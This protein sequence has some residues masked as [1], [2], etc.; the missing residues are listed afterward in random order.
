MPNILWIVL[1][2]VII[3]ALVGGLG[4]GFHGNVAYHPYYSTGGFSIGGILLLLLVLWFLGV[5]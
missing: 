5:I 4:M 2:V 1:V 3:L